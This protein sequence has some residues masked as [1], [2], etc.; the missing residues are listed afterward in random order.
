MAKRTRISA[1]ICR[2]LMKQLKYEGYSDS[3]KLARV[4]LEGFV[5]DAGVFSADTFYQFIPKNTFSKLRDKLKRDRFIDFTDN[6]VLKRQYYPGHRILPFVSQVK[7]D[8]F[9]TITY[10]EERM[11]PVV[12]DVAALHARLTKIE[13]TV[14]ELRIAMEPPDTPEKRQTA[15]LAVQKLHKLTKTASN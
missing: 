6:S 14:E 13:A 12:D 5:F 4:L 11:A 10:V 2:N 15:K 3:G 9:A 8:S 1:P 7:K